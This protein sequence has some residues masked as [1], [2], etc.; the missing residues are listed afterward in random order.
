M[1]N[2]INAGDIL[3]GVFV[4]LLIVICTYGVVI[5]G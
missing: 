4:L 1:S 2:E 5:N 3:I